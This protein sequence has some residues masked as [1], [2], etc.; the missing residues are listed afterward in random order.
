MVTTTL[1][2]VGEEIEILDW[3]DLGK[4][5]YGVRIGES[6]YQA[7]AMGDHWEFRKE[8]CGSVYTVWTGLGTTAKSCDCP[9]YRFRK[10]MCKHQLAVNE[11][12][13]RW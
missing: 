12:A 6:F 4:G 10:R 13:K 3:L 7:I 2:A 1:T 5:V 9:D 8:G 11:L